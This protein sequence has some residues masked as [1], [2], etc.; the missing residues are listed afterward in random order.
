MPLDGDDGYGAE[1]LRRDLFTLGLTQADLTRLTGVSRATVWRW[2]H[3]QCP[4][5][6]YAR[7][8]LQQSAQLRRLTARLVG[9]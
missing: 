6:T 8:I 7:T 3:G 9:Q 4:V 2:L 1:E 5:P